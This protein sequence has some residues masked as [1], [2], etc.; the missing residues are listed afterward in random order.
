MQNQTDISHFVG[1]ISHAFLPRLVYQLEE[2]G[3]PRMISKKIQLSGAF[4]FESEDD[5]H[6]AIKKLKQIGID[7]IIEE[8]NTLVEFDKYILKHFFEG[9]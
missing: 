6:L 1:R 9:I 7:K 2:Y 5:L 4:D 3:L 8:V